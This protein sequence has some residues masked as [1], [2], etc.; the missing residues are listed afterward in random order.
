MN[1]KL[2]N[3]IV[4]SIPLITLASSTLVYVVIKIA[5]PSGNDYE[6]SESISVSIS[7]RGGEFEPLKEK[8]LTDKLSL[9]AI[10]RNFKPHLFDY[11]DELGRTT[12]IR[13]YRQ[14]NLVDGVIDV[15]LI[16]HTRPRIEISASWN[17]ED[18]WNFLKEVLIFVVDENYNFSVLNVFHG[19]EQK[20]R[21]THK[22]VLSLE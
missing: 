1:Q 22:E 2:L 11:S 10:K 14:D 5:W 19:R 17:D 20:S 16:T 13:Y 18:Y 8:R 4:L 21:L 15:R 6:Y 12:T 9:T 3:T 7:S